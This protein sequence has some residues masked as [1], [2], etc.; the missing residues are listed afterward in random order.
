MKFIYKIWSRYDGFYPGR[1]P[2]RMQRRSL[3]LGWD[4]YIDVVEH[5][6][7]IW[8]YFHGP[9]A[10][11]N[12]VYVKGFVQ[13][14]NTSAATV[15]L[16]VREYSTTDPLTDPFLSTRVA[17]LAAPRYRQVFVLPEQW[18]TPPECTI[19]STATSCKRRLCDDC[20]TWSH[21]PLIA[22]EEHTTPRRLPDST[23]G[24]AP[25]YWVI[26]SRCYL[27]AGLRRGVSHTS[28]LF[29]RFKL[30]EEA[31][32]YPLALGIFEALRRRE[33]V[34]FDAV[35]PIPLSPEKI[36]RGELH[37]TRAL[38][39]ELAQLLGARMHDVL[40]L[41]SPFSKKAALAAGI[42]IQEFERE[43]YDKLRLRVP[44][45]LPNRILLLDDVSTRGSTLRVARR[46]LLEANPACEIVT[47]TA[48][49]M[50]LKEV[51]RDDHRLIVT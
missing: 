41:T 29:Y 27:R 40:E 8:V 31:L 38:A 10:F 30:G 20:S 11:T 2:D 9:H 6:Q 35:V 47:A 37:R 18:A 7:E 16:R 49:Q 14:I 28:E 5:G 17:A 34:D 12:G 42:G 45:R 39:S 50:I 3:Q 22:P 25:A 36:D 4:R 13:S 51:V 48:G 23:V 46:R 44:V 21:L 33:L 15:T 32:A 24:F 26:P 1:V 43:Y 19:G